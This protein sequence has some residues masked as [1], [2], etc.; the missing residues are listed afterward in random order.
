MPF[1]FGD[2]LLLKKDNNQK[3]LLYL[4]ISKTILMKRKLTILTQTEVICQWPKQLGF[5]W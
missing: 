4:L 1:Y 3:F 2:F 5:K